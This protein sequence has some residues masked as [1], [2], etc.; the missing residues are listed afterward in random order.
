MPPA[1]VPLVQVPPVLQP[2]VGP[3]VALEYRKKQVFGAQTMHPLIPPSASPQVQVASTELQRGIALCTLEQKEKEVARLRRLVQESSVSNPVE[4]VRLSNRLVPLDRECP[5]LQAEFQKT[6][7]PR[8]ALV[9]G[10]AQKTTLLTS[11][12]NQMLNGSSRVAGPNLDP[13]AAKFQPTSG[14][15]PSSAVHPALA[16][17][18]AVVGT[19]Q[20]TMQEYE[21][22]LD[23]QYVANLQWERDEQQKEKDELL[24]RVQR[25]EAEQ[26]HGQQVSHGSMQTTGVIEPP[27]QNSTAIS[28]ETTLSVRPGLTHY[29]ANTVCVPPAV[30]IRQAA[31]PKGT[32]AQLHPYL[33]LGPREHTDLPES[34][35][36][37]I[38]ARTAQAMRKVSIRPFVATSRKWV[39]WRHDFQIQMLGAGIPES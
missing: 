23:P 35:V 37:M 15:L 24:Q 33:Q 11:Q 34:Q 3:R 39:Q 12:V 30:N 31:A 28:G 20:I 17:A 13:S 38:D 6:Y 1:L 36:P 29:G 16:S 14:T 4:C 19:G 26:A 21:A 32:A 2:P 27:L 5:E 18:P 7:G 8:T 22:L 25:L 10:V 9:S